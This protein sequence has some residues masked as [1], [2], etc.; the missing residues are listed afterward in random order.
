MKKTILVICLSLCLALTLGACGGGTQS[1]DAPA[2]GN[3]P[4]AGDSGSTA[5]EDA[6]A[7]ANPDAKVVN[8]WTFHTD[9]EGE[10][11]ASLGPAYSAI[12][13]DVQ[14]DLRILPQDE[15]MGAALTSAFAAD[16]G[17]NVFVMSPGD[18]LKYANSGIALDLNPY[19]TDAMRAD[20]LESSVEACTVD[21]KLVGIP[22]EIELLGIYYNIDILEAA[23]VTPP[24]T[25]GELIDATSKLTTNE[26]AG[27][28]IEPTKGY[29]QNFTWYPFLWQGGGGVLDEAT[30]TGTFEGP[31][32]ENALKLWSDLVKAGAPSTLP[33][34]GT[35]DIAMIG[36]GSAAMQIC[37][38][39]PIATLETEYAD[40]NIGLIPLP[41]PDGGEPFTTAGGWKMMVS[42]KGEN[43]EEAAK[44]A[45]W[46]FAEDIAL[47]LQWCTE[48]KFAYSPRRSVVEAGGAIYEKGL[49]KVFTDEIYSTA[50]GEP[51]YPAEIV[52]AV[53]DALQDVMLGGGDPAAAAKT[54]ND[55]INNFLSS[56]E[57]S[58]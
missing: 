7:Q 44:F 35:W 56:F 32:V 30:M 24:K 55:K 54:A 17:P 34:P 9:A 21:G 57:G 25:W 38:T 1:Q 6:P 28:V 39:W 18:F 50:V 27:M 47:P 48:V 41:I 51:R 20:F 33:I 11:F 10:F 36:D 40:K 45:L 12:N 15:Y 13:P 49:R 2:A 3:A 4:V 42:S 26:V 52:D 22:F 43:Y 23:G 19:F 53:G 29:Y 14:V 37:G 8:F 31:A 46:A 16:V 5:S 58:M